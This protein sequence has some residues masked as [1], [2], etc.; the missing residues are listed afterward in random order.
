MKRGARRNHAPAFKASGPRRHERRANDWL[1]SRS[2]FIATR[3]RPG[4]RSSK[5]GR[6]IFLVLAVVKPQEPVVDVKA[7]HAKT[8]TK[9][10]ANFVQRVGTTGLG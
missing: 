7:L 6:P 2:T 5:A 3:L 8:A 10:W 1:R 9:R 4:K